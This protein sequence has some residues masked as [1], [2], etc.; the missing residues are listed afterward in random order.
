MHC[1]TRSSS[2]S[3]D[4]KC[5]TSVFH[6]HSTLG[7]DD[8]HSALDNYDYDSSRGLHHDDLCRLHHDAAHSRRLCQL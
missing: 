1:I 4:F 7:S 6:K 5:Q 3:D 2:R 8:H